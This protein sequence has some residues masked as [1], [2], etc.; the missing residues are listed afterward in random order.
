[1]IRILIRNVDFEEREKDADRRTYSLYIEPGTLLALELLW[2]PDTVR[3][4]ISSNRPH[5]V[6]ETDSLDSK[7]CFGLG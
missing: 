2:I 6:L 7:N 3:T 5:Q 1:M 4:T